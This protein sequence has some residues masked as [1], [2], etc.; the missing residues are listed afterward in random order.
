LTTQYGGVLRATFAKKGRK[1]EKGW[2]KKSS[3]NRGEEIKTKFATSKKC[4]CGKQRK[5]KVTR[6]SKGC[7]SGN[8]ISPGH[9]KV[10]NFLWKGGGGQVKKKSRGRTSWAG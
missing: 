9:K 10:P 1:R 3:K 7:Q 4:P 2:E 5:E 6:E 8:E